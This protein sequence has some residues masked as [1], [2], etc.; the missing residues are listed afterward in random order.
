MSPYD[1]DLMVAA[2][3]EDEKDRQ[4][5]DIRQTRQICWLIYTS[6]ADPKKSIKS[7]DKWWPIDEPKLK[8]PRR[9]N[10]KKE[11][12]LQAKINS[13]LEKLNNGR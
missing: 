7:I 10:T 2:F 4:L 11:Q 12:A 9:R 3:R 8:T 5:F 1:F 6:N 13:N